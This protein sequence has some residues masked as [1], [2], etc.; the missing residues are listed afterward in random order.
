[1]VGRMGQITAGFQYKPVVTREQ[2]MD[3]IRDMR[4]WSFAVDYGT[5]PK[6]PLNPSFNFSLELC[7]NSKLIASFY[8]H[9]VVQ[10]RVKN[11]FEEYTVVGITNYIDLGFEFQSRLNREESSMNPGELQ[12][13]ASWQANKNILLKAKL[14]SASS[15]AALTFKSWWQPSFLFSIALMRDHLNGKTRCGFGVHIDNLRLASYERADPNYVMLTPTKEHIAEGILRNLDKRPML[16]TDV[17][18]GKY[19]TLPK[20]LHPID[21]IL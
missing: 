15:A 8:Q 1:M 10:R 9:L 2:P 21:N 6:G 5:G 13:A 20:A 14:G 18:S 3:L 7:N 11:P 17:A 16:Q 12:I 4:N 19:S